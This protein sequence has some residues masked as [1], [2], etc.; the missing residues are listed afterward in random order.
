MIFLPSPYEFSPFYSMTLLTAC[1]QL[2]W[3]FIF[4]LHICYHALRPGP[5]K[6]D[7]RLNANGDERLRSGELLPLRH[8]SR[9]REEL[10]FYEAQSS[11]LCWGPDEWFWTE[12]F[13]VET[14]FGSE[15]DH[16]TYLEDE[17]DPPLAGGRSLQNPCYDPREYFL[18]KL[19]RRLEQATSEYSALI[20]T[21]NQRMKEYVSLI[22]AN[23][24][25]SRLA[26]PCV[27]NSHPASNHPW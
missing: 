22:R 2:S 15:P 7:S 16:K 1:D 14:W 11:S 20:G 27:I 19:D 9:D 8:D 24:G 23:L 18:L 12:L 26:R 10:Y 13:L 17:C 6:V 4:E 21:F 5:V 3:G 25:K